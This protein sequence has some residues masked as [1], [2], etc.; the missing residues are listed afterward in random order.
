MVLAD[1]IYQTTM[2]MV[3]VTVRIIVAPAPISRP[4]VEPG[5][6]LTG[7]RINRPVTQPLD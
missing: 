5:F 1:E 6:S 4:V 3:D 7:L 2:A